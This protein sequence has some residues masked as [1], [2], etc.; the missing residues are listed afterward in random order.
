MCYKA[1]L[2]Q[3][4][5]DITKNNELVL[6]TDSECRHDFRGDA[7]IKWSECRHDFRGITILLK[8]KVIKKR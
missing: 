3:L 6:Q 1:C 2:S 7:I 5:E 4:S 8:R